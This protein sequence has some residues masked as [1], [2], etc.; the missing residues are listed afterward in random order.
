MNTFFIAYRSDASKQINRDPNALSLLYVIAWRARRTA[1]VDWINSCSFQLEVGEALIGD[2]EN[3][4]LTEKEYREAKKRL[5]RWGY[6]TFRRANKGT[7]AK[8]INQD[9]FDINIESEADKTA[10]STAIKGRAEGGQRATNNNVKKGNNDNNKKQNTFISK[11]NGKSVPEH[12]WKYVLKNCG[13]N[14][15]EAALIFYRAKGADNLSNYIFI[16]FKKG[17]I[18]QPCKDEESNS[19]KVKRWIADFLAKIYHS[20]TFPIVKIKGVE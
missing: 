7:I 8:L 19:P 18:R 5:E 6:A 2:F 1:G 15:Y 12:L 16:G 13:N 10:D 9:V 3:Y 20:T 11:I 14:D 17:Y 4:G